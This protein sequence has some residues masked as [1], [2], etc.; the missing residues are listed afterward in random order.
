[1]PD[2]LLELFSEEI[3]ARMQERAAEDLCRLVETRLAALQLSGTAARSYVTPRRLTLVVEGL[4]E[5]QPDR[6]VEVKGPRV[7]APEQATAGFLRSAGLTSIE[8]TEIRDTGKGSFHFAVTNVAGQ[9]IEAAL[10]Q[11]LAEVLD[12]F[13]W[14]KSMRWGGHSVRWVRPLHN[15]LA[16][17]TRPGSRTIVPLAWALDREGETPAVLAA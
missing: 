2:L 1:M 13:P 11:I 15:I 9:A 4:P 16:I 3:P 5:R 6:K 7:G 12:S 8:Q 17:L 10:A 14:P